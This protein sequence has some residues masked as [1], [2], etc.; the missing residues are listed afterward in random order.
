MRQSELS[1]SQ[2]NL[3]EA[4]Y[5]LPDGTMLD[6][7]GRHQAVGYEGGKVMA[8]KPDYLAKHPER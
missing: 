1:A 8:G 3:N 4:G 2:K 6:F 7:S 5:V